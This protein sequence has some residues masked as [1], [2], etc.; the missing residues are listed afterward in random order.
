MLHRV[1]FRYMTATAETKLSLPPI[2]LSDLPEATKDF[3][4][5]SANAGEGKTPIQVIKEILDQAA[6][7][8]GFPVKSS[9][10]GRAA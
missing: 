9:Q 1:H 5:A 10:E 2:A 6:T 4:L 8:A 3:L 7:R